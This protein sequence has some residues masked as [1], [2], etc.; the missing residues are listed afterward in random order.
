MLFYI[1]YKVR[2]KEYEKLVT[3]FTSTEA[4]KKVQAMYIRDKITLIKINIMK[5]FKK[6]FP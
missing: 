5:P 6:T 2:Q 3:A 4:I 1:E